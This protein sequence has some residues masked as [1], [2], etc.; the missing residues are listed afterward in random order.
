MK[1]TLIAPR[2]IVEDGNSEKWGTE[3]SS[4]LFGK[5][6]Y[7]SAPLA[8]ATIA[9]LT[10]PNIEVN[11][12]DENIEQIDFDIDTNLV[13]ITASTFLA[14]RA[15][16]IADEFRKRNIKVILG[17]IHP[18]MLPDEAIQHADTVVIGEAEEVWSNL[19]DDCKKN[20]LKQFYQSTQKPDLSKQPI[21]R[22]DLLKNNSYNLHT[23]QT[24]RGCPFD[25]EFCSVKVFWGPQYRY[26]SIEKVL[27]E[28]ETAMM[29]EKKRIFFV[30]DNFI[31]NKKRTK[32]LLNVLI[33]LKI[34]YYIQASVDLAN[35]EELLE[36]LAKSGCNSVLIGFE[37]ISGKVI[38][39]MNK[40]YSNKVEGYAQSI[41]KIQ[42]FGIGIQGSFIFG[43]DSDDVSVFEKTVNF[44][45]NAELEIASLHVL[46]PFPGT[47]LSERLNSE[48]R[49]LHKDWNKYDGENVCFRP[50]LM[51]PEVLQNGVVW[52]QQKVYTFENIFTRLKAIWGLWN[53]KSVRLDD[54]ISPMIRNLS[55]NHRAYTYSLAKQPQHIEK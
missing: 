38:E 9:A 11:I 16:E 13:G 25:C 39:Q 5:K 28:V 36:L 47:K 51:A 42:S 43:Y 4:F 37:S 12:I 15:Y 32:E 55:S 23:I 52:A 54:R 49:I 22:W 40:S 6:K 44:V 21:P 48:G 26:K 29:L 46:T 17:G 31:G 35:D 20:K 1:I 8:L 53:E 34:S 33:P 2:Q 7:Y 50:K 24:T 30:D 10:P 18:S 45:Q 27:K 3:F 41:K 14:P 19:I